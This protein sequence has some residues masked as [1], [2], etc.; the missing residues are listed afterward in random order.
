[1]TQFRRVSTVKLIIHI[2]QVC[3]P[4]RRTLIQVLPPTNAY[5][6]LFATCS[7]IFTYPFVG[8]SCIY[9]IRP[10]CVR[11]GCLIAILRKNAYA[12]ADNKIIRKDV[13][14]VWVYAFWVCKP[15]IF[16]THW[17]WPEVLRPPWGSAKV[18]FTKIIDCVS[19]EQFHQK[20]IEMYDGCPLS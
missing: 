10:V 15:V 11:I 16:I 5:T 2:L 20:H 6:K 19:L 13:V 8:H 14:P 7:C 3:I 12:W 1:M 9:A 4:K 17:H 18:I